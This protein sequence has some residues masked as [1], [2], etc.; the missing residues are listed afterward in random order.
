MKRYREW[1]P[2]EGPLEPSDP[3]STEAWLWTVVILLL[4]ISALGAIFG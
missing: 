4:L 3:L 1:T 2:S